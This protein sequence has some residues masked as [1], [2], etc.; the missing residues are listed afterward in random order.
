M[1]RQTSVASWIVAVVVVLAIAV[2]GVYLMRK[3]AHPGTPALASSSSAPAPSST[4]I[5]PPP[6]RHPIAQAGPAAAATAVLPALDDSDADVAA[7]LASLVGGDQLRGLLVSRQVIARMVATLDALPRHDGVGVFMLPAHPPKGAFLTT[8]ADGRTVMDE[9]NA[10][11]YAPYMQVVD[12]ADPKAV[13]AWYVRY[14]PLFQQAYQQLGYPKA[15]FNDRL[16]VVIDDLLAAPDAVPS[17][18]LVRSKSYY[19]YADPALES[20]STGQKML[21]RTG[22]ANEA[23][24][25]A[26]LRIVRAGLIGQTLPAAGS[27][28]AGG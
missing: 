23:K 3:G 6:I 9:D 12:S 17:A 10:A 15:Y 2:A 8:Q 1:S 25:K 24:I 27:V 7:A 5:A 16:I 18:P 4:N 26:K 28:S 11:R 22:P 20:L 19:V 21:L 14:Y 13:V